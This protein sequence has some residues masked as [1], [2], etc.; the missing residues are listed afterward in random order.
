MFPGWSYVV[1][2]TKVNQ[3]NTSNS[4]FVIWTIYNERDK[5]MILRHWAF[6]CSKWTS[7]SSKKLFKEIGLKIK[8]AVRP[9]PYTV[10]MDK[11]NQH[12]N[13]M[14]LYRQT[15]L[16]SLLMLLCYM[17]RP[18]TIALLVHLI[19]DLVGT[20]HSNYGIVNVNVDNP[21]PR[22]SLK[23]AMVIGRNM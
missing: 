7:M 9:I 1:S 19:R 11:S 21:S 6:M 17:F 22:R 20:Y 13:N 12:I 15:Q 18:I 4:T 5:W 8:I 3:T 10:R 23:M 16:Y 2:S 14:G